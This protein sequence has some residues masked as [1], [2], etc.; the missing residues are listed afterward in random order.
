MIDEVGGRLRD[1]GLRT[2]GDELY[3]VTVYSPDDIVHV[4]L[5]DDLNDSVTSREL[6]TLHRP[7]QNIHQTLETIGR[8]NSVGG[9]HEA[10]IHF[11][12]H[13]IYLHLPV[14]DDV[15]AIVSLDR[16][17]DDYVDLFQECVAQVYGS[18][19]TSADD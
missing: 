10:S 15:G 9:D 18:A 14:G 3:T 11:F 4:Y 1:I 19:Y 6:D 16:T 12:E 17:S 13:V 8:L 7:V 2:A 5:A